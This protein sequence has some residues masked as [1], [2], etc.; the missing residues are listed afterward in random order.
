MSSPVSFL[1][2]VHCLRTLSLVAVDLIRL[3]ALAARPRAALVAEN[4]FLR[5]QLALFQER[6]VRPRRADAS[7]RWMMAALSEWFAWRDALVNVQ[8][9]TLLRWHRQGFRLF[10]RWK[11]KKAGRLCLPE[12]SNC[13]RT[14]SLSAIL[15]FLR[16]AVDALECVAS[17][18]GRLRSS[19]SEAGTAADLPQF[20]ELLDELILPANVA[21][22][23]PPRLSFSDH[24]HRLV[25]LDRP[26]RRLEFPKSLARFHPSFDRSMILLQ[27]VVQ[28]LGR[29][30]SAAAAQGSFLLYV[31]NG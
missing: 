27:D 25:A 1:A 4:L 6:K 23:H 9:D 5:K 10:W 21:A 7:I 8:A 31:R 24:V 12:I 29:S 22:A 30:M 11:S 3:A 26:L 14:W 2:V 13:M 18:S 19:P 20:E 15:Q 28:I 16:L 17:A